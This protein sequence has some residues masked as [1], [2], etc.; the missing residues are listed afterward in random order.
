MEDFLN[1]LKQLSTDEST[2]PTRT[3]RDSFSDSTQQE[4]SWEREGSSGYASATS[5]LNSSRRSS[6]APSRPRSAAGRSNELDDS[7]SGGGW[8]AV[9]AIGA[10]IGIG[11]YLVT[12][13]MTAD[14]SVLLTSHTQCSESLEKIKA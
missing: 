6:E 1:L 9:G 4:N 5:S 8:L 3:S 2:T 14:N 7:S 12:K 11:A 13:A 10:A